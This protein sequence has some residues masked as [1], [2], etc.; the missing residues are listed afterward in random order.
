[1]KHTYYDF[2]AGGGMAGI[3]LGH[4]WKCLFANEIDAKKGESYRAN[5]NGGTE[6][7]LRDVAQVSV[8]DIPDT[9]DLVW[10]SFPCQDMSLA[11]KGAGLSGNRSGTFHNFWELLVALRKLERSPKLICVE[12]VYGVVT[13]NGGKDFHAICQAY[14]DLG[15]NFG[16]MIIDAEHFVPQSRPRFFMIGVR[17]DLIL[18]GE[19]AAA[20]ANSLWHPRKLIERFSDLNKDLKNNWLWW[21]L[22]KPPVRNNTLSEIIENEPLDAKWN[23]PEK[24]DYIISLMSD[25]NKAKLSEAKG[26]GKRVVGTVYR[27]TRPLKDGT[28]QQRAEV[29]FDDVAGCL[30]T[31]AGGSSRQTILVVDGDSVRSRLLTAREAASLMGLPENYILPKNY[32]DAYKLAGDGVAV[33]VVRHLSQYLFEPVLEQ[34]GLSMVA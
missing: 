5:R 16:A 14:A 30:R 2:F 11:G 32:N 18:S 27:R 21:N 28:K 1:M 31:P 9:A 29:R 22:P 7:L 8:D 10:A 3:G 20:T 26:S 17:N 24:T 6:L 33:P 19:I 25:V 34:N 23:S 15:Y 4:N 12:N 13:S